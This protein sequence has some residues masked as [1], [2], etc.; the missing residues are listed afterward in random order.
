M[1]IIGGSA[2]DVIALEQLIYS[3]L[4]II[5][6]DTELRIAVSQHRSNLA[7]L[8]QACVVTKPVAGETNVI[9]RSDGWDTLM[10]ALLDIFQTTMNQI[11][12]KLGDGGR[13]LFQG[14]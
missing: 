11:A 13:V 10:D 8:T 3:N 4:R 1:D 12:R 5:H 6:P 9:E 7:F 2:S 14:C